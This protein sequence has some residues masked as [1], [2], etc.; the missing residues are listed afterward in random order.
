MRKKDELS[1]EHTCMQHAHPEEMVFVLL[2]RD[3]AAPAAIRAWAAER[4]RLGK[5][6]ETDEQIVEA[7]ACA[8]TMEAEGR[9]WADLPPVDRQHNR[10]KLA[11]EQAGL[12]I[13]LAARLLD[14]PRYCLEAL[15]RGALDV[16][17]A[18]AVQMADRYGVN[19]PWLLGQTPE[20][21]YAPIDRIDGADRLTTHDRNV[22]AQFAAS[23]PRGE[24]KKP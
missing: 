14:I 22:L 18:I 12:S 5:N 1:K 24:A 16:D 11:R 10:C 23:M 21:D 19:V 7:L 13:P 4:I 15:E 9:R 2:S 3:A 6:T 8:V 17:E 20:R